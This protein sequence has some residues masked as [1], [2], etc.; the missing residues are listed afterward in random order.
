MSLSGHAH[1]IRSVAVYCGSNFGVSP[2]YQE[3][4]GELGREI[5]GRGLTLVYGGTHTGLMGV[6]ADAALKAGGTVIGVIYRR[7][8]E[9]G[10]LHPNLTRY[11]ITES[12][13][14]RKARMVELADAFVA[15]PGGLGTFEELFE[16]ATLTQVGDHQKPCGVLNVN[17]F[18]ESLKDMLDMSVTQQFMK[19]EHRDMILV[20]T[21]PDVLLDKFALW[22]APSVTKWI[23]QAKA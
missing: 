23:N 15:L 8:F 6:V 9:R 10:Q 22:R 4:A 17:G 11:E 14:E 16:V 21:C 3:I 5:A 7:L 18:Y 19:I 1:S 13:H 12:K 2:V 20:E